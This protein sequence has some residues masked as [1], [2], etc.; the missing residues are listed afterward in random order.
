MSRLAIM[1]IVLACFPTM[2]IANEF[3]QKPFEQNVVRSHLVI[4]G[5]AISDRHHLLGD[6]SGRWFVTFSATVVLKGISLKQYEILVSSDAVESDPECC[7]RGKSYLLLVRKI[8]D[9][10]FVPTNGRFSVIRID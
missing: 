1:C 3:A 10:A 7:S 5:K 2:L 4:V 9:N 6:S 8:G